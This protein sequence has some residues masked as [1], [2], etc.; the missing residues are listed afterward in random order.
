MKAK[1]KVLTAMS[2]GARLLI[3]DEPTSGLDTI[4]RSEILDEIRNYMEVEG[5]GVIISSHIS[6]D[7]ENLCDDLY[8]IHNGE[9][10]FHEDTDSV[11]SQYALLKVTDTQYEKLDKEYILYTKK[12]GF[13]YSLLTNKRQFYVENYPD[14][15][16]EKGNIDEVVMMMVK[17]AEV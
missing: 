7:L 9:V 4:T 10:V 11:L 13:G 8:F 5:R 3:L 12:E 15:V 14:I 1:L 17:G 2:Y 16:V 6:S